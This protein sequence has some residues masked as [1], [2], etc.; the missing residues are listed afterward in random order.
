[1]VQT[2]GSWPQD[3]DVEVMAG[4]PIDFTVPA[5]DVENALVDVSTWTGVAQIRR[6]PGAPLLG[7][8]SL[9]FSGVGVRVQAT[10][11][12]TAAW[13][14][15]PLRAV[16]WDLWVTEPAEDPRPLARGRVLVRSPISEVSS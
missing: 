2:V 13:G 8:F 7:A 11:E 5:L 16:R 10:G 12:E 1:M 14:S 15:W 9:T 3:V 4:E 6:Y